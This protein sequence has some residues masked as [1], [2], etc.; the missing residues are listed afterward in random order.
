MKEWIK[1]ASTLSLRPRQ[2]HE[3][4]GFLDTFRTLC[5]A[6]NAELRTTFEHLSG[7]LQSVVKL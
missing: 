2:K 1:Y 7:G 6:P 4:L 5:V 3:W